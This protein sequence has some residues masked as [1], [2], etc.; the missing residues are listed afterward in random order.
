MGAETEKNMEN[1]QA[2][3]LILAYGFFRCY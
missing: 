3:T 1:P 2:G